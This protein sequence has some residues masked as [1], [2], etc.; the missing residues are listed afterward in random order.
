[1]TTMTADMHPTIN[2]LSTVLRQMFAQMHVWLE[3]TVRDLT[4]ES[5]HWQPSGR[6]V[7]AGAHYA[8]HVMGSEDMIFNLVIRKATPLALGAWQGKTGVS[9]LHPKPMSAWDD[10]ARRVQIDVPAV[11]EY[12]QAVY[13]NTDAYL[14]SMTIE[15]WYRP[16]DL[17]AIGRP[18]QQQTA[19]YWLTNILLDGAG[20]SG[21][22]SAVKGL[23]GLQ[24][25]PF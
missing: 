16:V 19:G 20:H 23:Q 5:C 4:A 3:S 13:A 10:W 21:E 7:P 12:A 9:E 1:M 6:V 18:G 11:R 2:E 24:G 17:S 14:A 22:I 8:H 15:E 25:Y